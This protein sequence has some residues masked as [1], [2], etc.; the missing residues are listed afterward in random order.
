MPLLIIF[1]TFPDKATAEGIARAL[2]EARLVACVNLLPGVQSVYRWE[3]Q[4]ESAEEVLGLMKTTA[5]TYPQ[6][7]GRLKE[8]HPYEVPEIVA[9][10]AERVEGAYAKWV[11][12]MTGPPQRGRYPEEEER[13][14]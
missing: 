6:L 14:G 4:V 7:E 9:V 3:G 11:N 5:E 12:E 10:P 1:C 13:F 2:V 8:L